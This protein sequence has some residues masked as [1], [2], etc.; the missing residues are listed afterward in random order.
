MTRI[1][2]SM[3]LAAAATPLWV[4]AAVSADAA[5]TCN[6]Q[7]LVVIAA[8]TPEVDLFDAQTGGKRVTS[9]PKAKFPTCLPI[10]EQ[11]PARMLK[12]DIEGT[13]YWVQPHMVMVRS[14]AAPPVCRNLAGAGG[15]A[16][17]TTRGLGEGC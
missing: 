7:A 4:S 1:A 3:L 8:R 13:Q 11:S 5:A 15:A 14:D 16:V 2:L 9:I 6:G 17:G 10:L 12:V